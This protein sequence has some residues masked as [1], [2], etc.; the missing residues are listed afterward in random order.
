MKLQLADVLEEMG[1]YDEFGSVIRSILRISAASANRQAYLGGLI[2]YGDY[3]LDRMMP[4]SALVPIGEGLSQAGEDSYRLQ[5]INQKGTASRL[6]GNPGE[7]IRYYDR[8]YGMADS[9]GMSRMK[10]RISHNLFLAHRQMGDYSSA[11]EHLYRGLVQSEKEKGSS[12]TPLILKDIGEL[13]Y[14]LGNVEESISHLEESER[15]SRELSLP[16]IL[17]GTLTNLGIAHR[18]TGDHPLAEDYLEEARSLVEPGNHAARV[19]IDYNLGV[20][21]LTLEEPETARLIFQEALEVSREK[22]IP[23][24]VYYNS[25]GMGD[26]NRYLGKLDEALNWYQLALDTS[27]MMNSGNLIEQA[28]EKQYAAYRDNG[29]MR[30]ALGAVESLRSL[31]DSLRTSDHEQSRA[32]YETLLE[33]RRQ[34]QE[35]RI[36]TAQRAE[37]EAKIQLQQTLGTGIL[38]ILSILLALTFTLYGNVRTR[39]KLNRDLKERNKDISAKNR[40]LDRMNDIKNKLFAVVSHDLRGPLSS[41]KGLL[42]LMREQKLSPENLDKFADSLEQSLQDNATTMENLLAWAKTQMSGIKLN[43]VEFS[44]LQAADEIHSQIRFQAEQKN[45]VFAVA[46]EP[47]VRVLADYE[48][49]KLVI[50]NLVSN[51]VK[52]CEKGDRITVS[53]KQEDGLTFVSIRDT[54]VGIRPEDRAKIFGEGHYTKKGTKQEKGSGLGLV[55]CRQFIERHGGMIWFESE[56]GEGTTFTFTLPDQTPEKSTKPTT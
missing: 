13:Y 11:F 17:T 31:T 28:L 26:L 56:Y 16:S 14:Q 8:S 50:R 30:Q 21:N 18:E 52:F 49:V 35:N 32:Q 7:S 22:D 41:M 40:E 9:L 6:G 34:T 47:D 43:C 29:Q 5:F 20:L 4:D 54:G 15:I 2:K 10:A 27:R 36:L 51:A 44:L 12:L 23:E 42:H 33:S 48:I 55:L 24:G 38:I 19:K 1:S 25:L 3:Y 53:S 37:Q 46:V 39:E 45:L